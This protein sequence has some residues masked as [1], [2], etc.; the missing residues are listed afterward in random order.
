MSILE[1][2]LR[3]L[4]EQNIEL[5]QE[6]QFWKLTA[7]EKETEKINAMR[8]ANELRLQLSMSKNKFMSD[9]RQ[10]VNM[11]QTTSE[12][13]ISHLVQSST[14][15]AELL[16]AAKTHM[17]NW[18]ERNI[19]TRKWSYGSPVSNGKV[20][21]VPPLMLDGRSLQPVVSLSRTLLTN[22][23][24]TESSSLNSSRLVPRAVPMHLLQDV[25]IPLTRI[26]VSD[27]Q[28]NEDEDDST[29]N[30]SNNSLQD[31]QDGDEEEG[32]VSPILNNEE[33]VNN[34]RELHPI[35]E[36]A[37]SLNVTERTP[38]D[39]L[40]G[41]SW[42]L[43][44]P[45]TNGQKS[46]QNSPSDDSEEEDP[47]ENQVR[48]HDHEQTGQ[49]SK[50]NSPA[51]DSEEEDP[52]EN[53]VR[54]HNH[55]Q[56]GQ[57]SKQN[58]PADDSEEDDS[59]KEDPIENQVG[60]HDHEQTESPAFV[61]SEF[62]P[63]VRRRKCAQS[64]CVTP[65]SPL[66]MGPGPRPRLNSCNGRIL[67]VMLSKISFDDDV[68]NDVTQREGGQ[69]ID[70][71]GS[72]QPPLKARGL[73]NSSRKNPSI[74]LIPR[75]PTD[76][77]TLKKSKRDQS[78]HS[79]HDN[80]NLPESNHSRLT[81]NG[82]S[83]GLQGIGSQFGSDSRGLEPD[84]NDQTPG[85]PKRRRKR[86]ATLSSFDS[87][88]PNGSTSSRVIVLT[89]QSER[90]NNRLGSRTS[91]LGNDSNSDSSNDLGAEGRPRRKRNPIQYTEKP[92]NRKL[93]R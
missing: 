54:S 29:S 44:Q 93:R 83:E 89:T 72:H 92:L 1:D 84:R 48:S 43:D 17:K 37:G 63:T 90:C 35:S 39:P 13:V 61:R 62:T 76:R 56:T 51:D 14:V 87:P 86:L 38:E 28:N 16:E 80:I 7:A 41:P 26:D 30:N 33:N 25:Y 49:K 11:L 81:V 10:L 78:P 4:R 2:K 36:E 69:L 8:D 47:I 6:L 67:K 73:A 68:R 71:G 59:E 23:N 45:T 40:E 22:N 9:S 42:L 70:D 53:Q 79:S 21:R 31:E 3:N 12:T 18:E 15:I 91:E 66:L 24:R 46:K 55:E 27:L 74:L 77:R 34:S 58:S 65:R 32:N 88:S 5:G 75:S 52:I 82:L 19:T 20:H 85:K 50:Q 60:S 64:P 57:K